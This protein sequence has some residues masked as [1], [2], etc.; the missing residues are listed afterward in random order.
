MIA[1]YGPG[2]AGT[3][4]TE[5][6]LTITS[7]GR[8]PAGGTIAIAALEAAR[9]SVAIVG[10]ANGARVAVNRSLAHY[11]VTGSNVPAPIWN[12]AT[13]T[14]TSPGVGGDG[15]IYSF[16]FLTSDVALYEI[17]LSIVGVKG[18]GVAVGI[19]SNTIAA[20]PLPASLV[21]LATGLVGVATRARRR[22]AVG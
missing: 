19:T 20:V 18:D 15:G 22:L 21:L 6:V 11:D 1:V 8:L 4:I 3:I 14:L 17:C 5:L 9:T 12:P 2:N 13:S 16:T 10:R 7:A